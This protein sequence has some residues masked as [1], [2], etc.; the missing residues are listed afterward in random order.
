MLEIISLV[1]VLLFIIYH[2]KNKSRNGLPGPSGLP[3]LGVVF[4]MDFKRVHL[5]LY[6]WTSSYGDIFQFSIFGKPYVRLI[7]SVKFLERNPMQ[8]LLHR[9]NHLSWVNIVWNMN[10]RL[11]KKLNDKSATY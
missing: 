5:K 1:V 9:G 10:L 4:Q 6:E 7:L 8:R 11:R 2:F 3:L